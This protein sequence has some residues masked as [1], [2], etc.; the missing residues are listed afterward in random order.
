MQIDGGE[1]LAR[2]L[3]ELGVRDVFALH[4]GHLDSFL[5][6][7]H[8]NG[9]RLIDV[10]HEATAGHAAEGY[11]RTTGGIGVCA[12]TAGPGFT[13]ALTAM[14]DAF[15]DAI[16]VLF[17]TSSPPLRETELNILQGNFDQVAVAAPV[18]KWAHRVTNPERLPDL[19]SLAMRKAFSGRPGPV[20]LDIPIDMFFTPVDERVVTRPS[21][22]EFERPAPSRVALAQAVDLLRQ[23]KRP[24]ML[25]GG[26][27]L[28]PKATAELL[29]FADRTGIPVYTTGK[30][31]GMLPEGHPSDC[32]GS[33]NLGA[34]IVSAGHPDVVILMG[35]RQGMY[36]GG[37]NPG[38]IAE[39][40]KI[41]QV[42]V[43][44]SELGRVRPVDVAIEAG[45]RE[46]LRALAEAPGSWP[47]WSEW[48][49]RAQEAVHPFEMMFGHAPAQA[50]DGRL[51][52][53]HASKALANALGRD[54]I[55][56]VDAGESG[57]WA[58]SVNRSNV[59][60][61][62]MS[63]GYLGT[64]GC[65]FGYAIGAQVAHPGK[66]VVQLVGDGAFGFHLQELNTMVRHRLPIIN[67]V[68]N[69][70]AWAIS[71][72]GQEGVYG[73][74]NGVIT[75]LNDA[76]YD[77]VAEAFGGYGERVRNF[78][79]I[80][81][82]VQRAMDSGLPAVLNV[83]TSA[84]VAHPMMRAM[85]GKPAYPGEIVIPYYENIPSDVDEWQKFKAGP[86]A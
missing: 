31:H 66:R 72:H 32:G 65:G 9:I 11:A 51:H 13:N 27:T 35:A 75:E 3:Y 26:G 1:I 33:G 47:D 60:G 62:Y 44:R 39:G 61:G 20:L 86:R 83:E 68:Y 43:E 80:P 14:V 71:R 85:V 36:T 25:T 46:T 74:G 64:L 37:R 17:I 34:L 42:D 41:I 16:P 73:V 29:A 67:V 48:T 70:S 5:Q 63:N 53:F 58:S 78:E 8:R 45:C 15:V 22:V 4:G 30:S 59:P 7:S 84:E 49:K 54:C 18:T 52:P 55:F 50:E 21:N 2:A 69:N 28:F 81:A 82:A 76:D 19:V 24:V 77:K 38:L 12:V 23:A 56:A 10:R 79:A 40:A 6:G 57:G